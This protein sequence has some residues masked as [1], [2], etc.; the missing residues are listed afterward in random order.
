MTRPE[1]GSGKI[2]LNGEGCSHPFFAL[3]TDVA[4]MVEDDV[5]GIGQAQSGAF[6]LAGKIRLEYFGQ[7]FFFDT[8]PIVRNGD[9]AF[10]VFRQGLELQ[11]SPT[12]FHCFDSIDNDI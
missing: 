1:A 8:G 11:D 4:V 3:E 5:L 2:E 9:Y 6:G 12:R 10:T 7:R